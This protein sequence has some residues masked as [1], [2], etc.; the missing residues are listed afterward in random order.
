MHTLRDEAE[1]GTAVSNDAIAAISVLHPVDTERTTRR[2][3]TQSWRLGMLAIVLVT[4]IW[5]Y[6]N[7]AIRQGESQVGPMMLLWLRFAIASV[8][9][10]PVLWRQRV[11]WR[12]ALRSLG[13]GALLGI[14]VL[15]QAWA[16]ESIPVDQVAFISALYVILTPIAVSWL[17]RT[18]P[19]WRIWLAAGAS[20]LGVVLVT[21]KLSWDMHVGLLLSFLAAVG[22]TAQIIG[23]T[24]MSRRVTPFA[25]TALQSVG[26]TLSLS[27]AMTF[28]RAG[29]PAWFHHW[30][31]W[32]G[33]DWAWIVYLAL[34]GTVIGCW[35]QV[36]GQARV[37]ASEAALAFNLE[38]VWTAVFAWV[39]LNQYLAV[40]QWLGALLVIGSLSLVARQS[41]PPK[42]TGGEAT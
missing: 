8:V 23:T 29:H 17:Q 12:D 36:W 4:A 7:V 42:H 13:V 1:V 35:L 27:V 21:G 31:T 20:L 41:S 11:P 32:T 34:V 39:V 5:G 38:P 33:A 15:L 40:P 24:R 37:S 26:A 10:A 18:W 16:M 14:P 2:L 19:Q 30:P 6:G 28:Q 3:R 9:L 25:L 22:F